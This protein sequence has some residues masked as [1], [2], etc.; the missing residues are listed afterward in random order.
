MLLPL[1]P[2]LIVHHMAAPH[3]L[4]PRNSLEAIRTCL[5][6][7]AAFVE[8]DI[9]ALRADDYLLVHDPVLEHE[10]NGSGPVGESTVE[11]AR[12][13]TYKSTAYS[14]ALLSDV[15]HPFLD[16]AGQTRLQLDFK[17][18][19]PMTE[20]EPL[21]RLVR[22]I[23]PLGERVIVSSGADWHLRRLRK[24]APWLD[25]GF[26]VHFYIDWRAAD[27]TIDPQVP[28]FHSGAYSYWDD[29][30]LARRRYWSTAEYLSERCNNLVDSVPGISTFY[31]DH[32][33]IAQSL[34][35][36]FN[37]AEAL[38][39]RSIKLDAWTLDMGN[40]VAE[41]NA[42]RLHA[43]GVDQFTSNTPIALYT[44]LSVR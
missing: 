20:D 22:L 36:G 11:S 38:H 2:P 33:L 8:V 18:V 10:T 44:W 28:P 9:T 12:Q 3:D 31:I 5:E 16:Q 6:Q 4:Y 1:S 14:V 30:I 42:R 43:A 32:K 40:P 26:D 15:V 41:I 35:D 19:L 29:H 39:A 21:R 24:L 37:W 17:N 25:L 27:E 34:D 7:Q 23:E 13:L